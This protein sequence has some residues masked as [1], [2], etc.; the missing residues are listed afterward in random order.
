MVTNRISKYILIASICLTPNLSYAEDSRAEIAKSIADLFLSA[1]LAINDQQDKI[2]NPDIGDKGI[3]T[4]F[5]ME[6]TRKYYKTI[7]GKEFAPAP[8]GTLLGDAQKNLLMSIDKVVTDAQPL[9]NKKGLGFKGFITAVYARKTAKDFSDRMAGK[10]TFKFTAPKDRLRSQAN[11]PDD[12]EEGVFTNQFKNATWKSGES[13]SEVVAL[14]DGTK[15]LRWMAPLN[16]E[17]YC[18]ECHGDPKGK[19]DITGMPREGFKLGD[20]AGAFSVTVR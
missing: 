4:Q 3:T 11:K 6:G 7:T 14:A 1:K 18:L 9:I 20:L 10:M 2:N 16:Y 13:Y 19:P 17:G 8:E 12:W 15:A 5:I